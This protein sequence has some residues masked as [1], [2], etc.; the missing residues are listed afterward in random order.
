M[1][2]LLSRIIAPLL[3]IIMT[4]LVPVAPVAAGSSC[5]NS[6]DSKGQVLQG[7]SVSGSNCDTSGVDSAVN[8]AVTILS[9]VV[10]IVAVIMIIIAGFKYLTSGGDANKVGSAKSTLIYAIIGIVIA[11][12]AQ[13]IVHYVVNT[14]NKSTTVH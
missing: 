5:P 1:K 10:G 13:V 6:N 4:S 12:L 9:Y 7:I 11:V 2:Q 3:I 8:A 14:A